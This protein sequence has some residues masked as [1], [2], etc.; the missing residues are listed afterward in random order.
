MT[1]THPTPGSRR[2]DP[3][4]LDDLIDALNGRLRQ[5]GVARASEG[6]YADEPIVF[7]GSRMRAATSARI[8]EMRALATSPEARRWSDAQLFVAQARLMEGHDESEAPRVGDFQT[9]LPTY[10][11]MTDAQLR[12][13]FAWR[14]ALRR[15]EVPGAPAPFSYVV[16][17]ELL[18][19]VGTTPGPEGFAAVRDTWQALRAHQ[20]SLDL[21]V[22][23]WLADYCAWHGLDPALAMPYV[24]AQRPGWARAL[25]DLQERALAAPSRGGRAATS[26]PYGQD[27]DLD[28]RAWEA[29]CGLS[30][31]DPAASPAWHGH[32][33]ELRR[34]CLSVLWALM[35]RQRSANNPS[36]VDA[37]VGSFSRMPHLMFASAVFWQGQGHADVLYQMG[38][39]RTYACHNGLW[40]LTG[41]RGASSSCHQMT[42]LVR[43]VDMAMREELGLTPALARRDE[44][45]YLVDLAHREVR[46]ALHPRTRPARSTSAGSDANPDDGDAPTRPVRIQ[47]DVSKLDAIRQDAEVTC[48]SLLVDEERDLPETVAG[49]S[50]P[51]AELEVP[52]DDQCSE[53]RPDGSQRVG[54]QPASNQPA[55]DHAPVEAAGLC[56]DDTTDEHAVG[57]DAQEEPEA[58]VGLSASAREMLEALLAG[59]RPEG[60]NLD[61]EVDEVNEALYDLLGDCAVQMG[62]DGMP[63]LVPDYVDDLHEELGI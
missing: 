46:E 31:H 13:Y 55:N 60:S 52:A 22:P 59:G 25:L 10:Q 29:V 11:S 40:T 17:Y 3:G 34:A 35:R 8:A 5:R 62:D 39:V 43:T 21:Y 15:G 56:G 41:L 63:E 28:A 33:D 6:T 36:L 23:T 54:N 37:W 32:A 12:A 49:T 38:S 26:L 27:P 58:L 7:R 2:R 19:G 30:A 48:E 50:A 20:P 53:Y 57:S 44:P 47:I 18:N 61:L 24:D 4:D 9:Y 16:L 14:T 42:R 45:K 1:G 51:V